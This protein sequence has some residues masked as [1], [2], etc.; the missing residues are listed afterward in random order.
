MNSLN[1]MLENYFGL[2]DEELVNELFE[3]GEKSSSPEQ[4][5]E[6]IAASSMCLLEFP[7]DFLYDLWGV[8]NDTKK[9]LQNNAE[10][11]S[12]AISQ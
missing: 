11:E 3:C 12:C 9:T 10:E 8:V 2:H 5:R 6:I 4:L 1:T 7:D